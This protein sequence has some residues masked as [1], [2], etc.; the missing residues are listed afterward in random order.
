[1][2]TTSLRAVRPRQSQ[3][4]E[5]ESQPNLLPAQSTETPVGQTPEG[6]AE[7][8]T[9]IIEPLI[10]VSNDSQE[11]K[12]AKAEK[13]LAL[14]LKAKKR[15]DIPKL[16]LENIRITILKI[17]KATYKTLKGRLPTLKGKWS[18]SLSRKRK[19][20][21]ILKIISAQWDLTRLKTTKRLLVLVSTR[22]RLGERQSMKPQTHRG[23][24]EDLRSRYHL[25][26]LPQSKD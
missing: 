15:M 17:L 6:N 12:I 4:R 22:A 9:F 19:R 16:G 23:R 20:R 18:P 8:N 7:E 26:A 10:Q 2:L 5:T 3:S 25:M 24:P 1:M 14:I 21:L 11:N 13:Q